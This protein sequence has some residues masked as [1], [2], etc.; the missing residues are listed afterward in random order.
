MNPFAIV[1]FN[2][3]SAVTVDYCVVYSCCACVFAVMQ[4]KCSSLV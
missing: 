3:C 4:G 1:I 2:V